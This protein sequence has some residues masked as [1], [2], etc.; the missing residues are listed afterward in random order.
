MSQELFDLQHLPKT[1]FKL[2]L[3][4]VMG[5]V[6]TLIY[7]LADTYFIA[8]TNDT[9]LV[10]GVSLCSPVFTTIMAFG[11]IYGQGGSSLISRLL[12]RKDKE[13]IQ[14]ISSF[15]FYIAIATGVLLGVLMLLFHVPLLHVIGANEDT[16]ATARE[17]FVILAIGTPCIILSFIHSNLLRCEGL[18]TYSMI[19]SIAG[20]VL[21]II[22][23]PI[24]ISGLHMGAAGAAIATVI[25]YAVSDL[26]FIYIVK[27]HSQWLSTNLHHSRASKDEVKQIFGVGTTAAIT[28]LMQSLC[29]IAMNQFLLPY[30]NDKIAAMGIVLRV[31]MISQLILT[32]FAFG[33]VPLF[34]YLYGSKNHQKMKEL[35]TFCIKFLGGLSIAL[36]ILIGILSPW[37][38]KMM[39]DNSA[40]IL[41]GTSMLRWQI[42]GT[43]FASF[44]LLLTC[45]F[46]A[47]A[48]I[49]PAFLLS[50]SR[51]G[52]LFIAILVI[53]VHFLGYE[54]ILI[55]QF[56]ADILGACLALLL[57]FKTFQK[58]QVV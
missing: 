22:L 6:V 10:A 12:G 30:G 50:I 35:L 18:S 3:P 4:V 51:Q 38:L 2:A 28:N 46:Q 15:C 8:Q 41:D 43:I 24:L 55:S 47:T 11:N 5:L 44:V 45:F 32:G 9:I 13:G 33:A 31:N 14:R 54:G 57:Y 42:A 34:G 20:T 17:Y 37:M 39:M 19:G 29:V 36:T 52:V 21:N 7:N 26:Y 23:D 48:K 58:K 16:F 49:I 56:I 25:G 40:I 53:F 1:Y 27:R